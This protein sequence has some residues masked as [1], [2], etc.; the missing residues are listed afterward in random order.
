MYANIYKYMNIKIYTY[1]KAESALC[2]VSAVT[3]H[4]LPAAQQEA[5]AAPGGSGGQ[6][7]VPNPS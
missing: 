7:N 1:T 5:G 6:G 3:G 4:V 2:V